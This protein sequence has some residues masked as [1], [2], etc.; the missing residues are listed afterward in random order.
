MQGAAGIAAFLF[1]IT[2]ALENGPTIQAAR[3]MDNCWALPRP[4]LKEP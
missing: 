3:R 1:H 2:R 4:F